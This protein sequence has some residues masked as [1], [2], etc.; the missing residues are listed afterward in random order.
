M[1][2]YR[3]IVVRTPFPFMG[4]G[5][6]R[7]ARGSIRNI[8]P[9]FVLPR[10]GEGSRRFSFGFFT[11]ESHKVR[12]QPI[13]RVGLPTRYALVGDI[14]PADIFWDYDVSGAHIAVG[15]RVST[16]GRDAALKITEDI[17]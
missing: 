2:A 3:R 13:S 8:T 14:L 15:F 1:A 12:L 6:D 16:S 17:E 11:T 4:K 9:T 7:G 5:R 10:Q